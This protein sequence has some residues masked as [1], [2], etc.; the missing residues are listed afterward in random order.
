MCGIFAYLLKDGQSEV[1]KK[2][3]TECHERAKTLKPRGPEKY[4]YT[5]P[6]NNVFMGF[7]RLSI[8]D[9]SENG[10]QPFSDSSQSTTLI[11]NGEI[12]NS[13]YLTKKYNLPVKSGSDCEVILHLYIKFGIRK[14]VECLDGDFAF[15]IYDK[16]RNEFICARD[17]YG[18]RPL[19]ISINDESIVISSELKALYGLKNAKVFPNGCFWLS[20]TDSQYNIYNYHNEENKTICLTNGSSFVSVAHKFN[21]LS[22][23]K[24]KEKIKNKLETSVKKRLQSDRKIGCLLSGGLDSSLV[25]SLVKKLSTDLG[26]NVVTYSV[27]LE[28]SVDLEAARKVA[29]FLGTEHHEIIFTDSIGL[30]SISDVIY[31]IETWDTTTVRASIP[32][33]LMCKYIKEHTPEVKVILSG[34]GADEV[35][36][37]YLYFHNQPNSLQGHKESVRLLQDLLYFD[38]LRS[39]RS[40]STHGL[41]VRVPFLDKD[42][43]NFYM[44]IPAE[45]RCPDK[46]K[47]EKWLLRESFSNEKLLPDEILW[48]Q[49][50]GLSDG[51]SSLNRPW[52]QIIQ[53]HAEK[54]I[55]NEELKNANEK[56]THCTP[57]TKESLMFRN[58]FHKHFPEKDRDKLTPY[59]WLPKW[60]GDITNPSGRLIPLLSLKPI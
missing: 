22:L 31:A 6:T 49:K 1:D 21:D 60:C 46:K 36:Q 38:V 2:W 5:T 4:K 8:V 44:S 19:F 41:E 48:R 35:C 53:E 50:D 54:E 3:I 37:G 56:Y 40:I 25:T 7:Q 42:F 47:G 28:G 10:D 20:T 57:K 30:N 26:W 43:V 12:Y 27:G 11:C 13:K 23:D 15:I 16:N 29:S 55:T 14:T 33:W 59:Q 32:M 39:D 18:V 51:C 17:S 45:Y 34:E 24:I 58:I 9:L 52:Y